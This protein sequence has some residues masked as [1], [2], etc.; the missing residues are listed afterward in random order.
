MQQPFLCISRKNIRLAGLFLFFIM[1]LF[2]SGCGLNP[3][4]IATVTPTI[5]SPT[6]EVTPT[7]SPLGSADN[8]LRIGINIQTDNDPAQIAGEELAA[9]L[10]ELTNL[11]FK[12]VYFTNA[13]DLS[14][15]ARDNSIQ[16][17][18]LNP[19]EYIE[20]K[21]DNGFDAGLLTNHYGVYAYGAQFIANKDSGFTSYFD[22]SNN[23]NTSEELTVLNQFDSKRPCLVDNNS[24]S[25]S[26]VPLGLLAKEGILYADPI[27]T[28]S[29][30]AIIRALY[31]KGICDFGATF[32]VTGDPRTSSAVL[33]DL[34]D[35][36]TRVEI[37][38]QTPAVIPNLNLSYATNVSAGDRQNINSA[39]LE[40]VKSEAGKSMISTALNYEVSDIK[41]VDDSIYD[42]LREILNATSADLNK[43]IEQ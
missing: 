31:I 22:P 16:L 35:A 6:P 20:L 11:N 40:I 24:L 34:P 23:K 8:P 29:H 7:P 27:Y 21:Q 39:F 1:L 41:I 30:T 10:N 25:G 42:D 38:W 28:H 17:A 37:I 33:N 14:G 18:W 15:A 43:I 19:I 36:L 26:L 9:K 5:I 12:F 3:A 13:T 2:T 4:S 32:S